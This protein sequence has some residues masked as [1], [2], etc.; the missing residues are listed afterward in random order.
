M[1]LF[2]NITYLYRYYSFTILDDD[3]FNIPNKM[4]KEVVHVTSDDTTPNND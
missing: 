2:N 3:L 1:K 4:N